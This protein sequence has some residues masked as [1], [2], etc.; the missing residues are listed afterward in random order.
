MTGRVLPA[1]CVGLGG[2]LTPAPLFAEPQG[3][4]AL[5]TAFSGA[6]EEGAIWQ[7]T[8]FYLGLTGDLLFFRERNRD[9]GFGPYLEL[10]TAGFFDVRWGGGASLLVPVLEDF[11]LVVSAG[12]YG[13]ELDALALG[14]TLF[15]GARSYNFGGAY[16]LALGV[17][18]SAFRDL[19][20]RGANLLVAGFELDGVL[21]AL[22]F[23]LGWEALQ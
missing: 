16:N 2:C 10:A 20:A 3:H 15:W 1:L 6:G 4:V 5:R 13:H 9:F 12:A 21:I 14:G 19:D 17:F 11:P 22:P 18:V 7:E 23:V 8:R